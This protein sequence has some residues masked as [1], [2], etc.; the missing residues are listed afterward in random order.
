[1]QTFIIFILGKSIYY[2]W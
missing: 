1:M 2:F